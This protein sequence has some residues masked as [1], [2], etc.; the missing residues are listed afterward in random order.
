MNDASQQ[1]SQTN[2]QTASRALDLEI[3]TC[4]NTVL[5]KPYSTAQ[6]AMET[7]AAMW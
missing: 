7:Q 6:A 4:L 1:Y 3:T 2:S 5:Y